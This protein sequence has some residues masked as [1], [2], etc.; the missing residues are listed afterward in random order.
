VTSTFDLATS[1]TETLW[2]ETQEVFLQWQKKSAG[3]PRLLGF[4]VSGLQKAGTDRWAQP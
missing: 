4:G 1:A 3:A 2:Q